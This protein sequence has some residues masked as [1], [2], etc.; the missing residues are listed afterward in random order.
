[1]NQPMRYIKKRCIICKKC[2]ANVKQRYNTHISD[3]EDCERPI[4]EECHKEME[5]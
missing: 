5:R 3:W 1:M 4:C 2:C